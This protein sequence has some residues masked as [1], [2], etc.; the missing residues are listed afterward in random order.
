MSIRP[1]SQTR[2]RIRKREMTEASLRA[3][4][5]LCA[6]EKRRHFAALSVWS[7]GRAVNGLIGGY[8]V[9]LRDSG[10]IMVAFCL[11]LLSPASSFA[12]NQ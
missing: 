2:H 8:G 11:L 12:Q 3:D 10:R 4:L 6:V 5:S 7:G 9:S 1:H